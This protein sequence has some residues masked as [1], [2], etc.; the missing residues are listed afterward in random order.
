MSRASVRLL[1]CGGERLA[2]MNGAPSVA[3]PL[4]SVQ[5]AASAGGHHFA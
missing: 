2:A 5:R 3:A 1:A 4:S